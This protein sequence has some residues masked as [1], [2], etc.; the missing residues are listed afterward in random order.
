MRSTPCSLG[1]AA[2]R[3]AEV[4]RSCCRGTRT[5][6]VQG[7]GWERPS[8][9]QKGRERCALLYIRR[10]TRRHGT[11]SR[12]ER[13]REKTDGW[14]TPIGEPS[15]YQGGWP[16]GENWKRLGGRQKPPARKCGI[17]VDRSRLSSSC[18]VPARR[19][20]DLDSVA[21]CSCYCKKRGEQPMRTGVFPL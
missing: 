2:P 11:P 16:I 5:R 13:T 20:W 12:S 1:H 7:L 9:R 4:H 17:A 19:R 15:G 8:P 10:P 14:M 3:C 6:I 21:V 18:S